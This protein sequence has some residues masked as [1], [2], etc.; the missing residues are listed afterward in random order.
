MLRQVPATRME[1]RAWTP[2]AVFGGQPAPCLPDPQPAL[3]A[4][5]L[6]RR[7][8]QQVLAARPVQYRCRPRPAQAALLFPD[9]HAGAH[10][11]AGVPSRR[12]ESGRMVRQVP[13][14]QIEERTEILA[15]MFEALAVR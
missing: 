6:R 4:P 8:Y 3:A 11:R 13:A 14:T 15:S 5:T 2:E 9:E 7:R 10:R 12:R 1:R